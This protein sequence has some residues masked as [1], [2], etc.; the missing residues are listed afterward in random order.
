MLLRSTEN[1]GRCD[2]SIEEGITPTSVGVQRILEVP[3]VSE[4]GILKVVS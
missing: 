3:I 1:C 4:Q 2:G